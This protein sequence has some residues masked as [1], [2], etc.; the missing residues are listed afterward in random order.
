MLR[1]T[2]KSEKLSKKI[3]KMVQRYGSDVEFMDDAEFSKSMDSAS[4]KKQAFAPTI[5]GV[6]AQE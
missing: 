5:E 1:P 6:K 3:M 2:D 4:S